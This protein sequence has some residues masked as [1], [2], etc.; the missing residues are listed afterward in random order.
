MY[1]MI[2]QSKTSEELRQLKNT[3]KSASEKRQN[4]HTTNFKMKWTVDNITIIIKDR[5]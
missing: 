1:T 4:I 5:K 3:L 2:Y